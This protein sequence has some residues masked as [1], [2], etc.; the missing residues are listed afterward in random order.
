MS[1]VFAASKQPWV[2]LP[3]ETPAV[4][5]YYERENYWPPGSLARRQV[6]L[7]L[8]EAYQAARKNGAC[9]AS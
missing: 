5:E 9:P 6:L 3:A 1:I 8:I 7:P 2:V 4:A